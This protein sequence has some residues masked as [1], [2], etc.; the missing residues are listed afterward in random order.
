MSPTRPALRLF[1]CIVYAGTAA[2]FYFSRTG[3][4]HLLWASVVALLLGIT[5]VRSN[6]RVSL[7]E[8]APADQ[9]SLLRALDGPNGLRIRL[10]LGILLVLLT[11]LALGMLD[12]ATLSQL[13][14]EFSHPGQAAVHRDATAA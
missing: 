9:D 14:L 10:G 4:R 6:G 1:W 13:L 8:E 5:A 7:R 11:L 2:I 3:A 12:P